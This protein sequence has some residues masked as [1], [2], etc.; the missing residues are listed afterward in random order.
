MLS[1]KKIT[2]NDREKID[3][4]LPYH[5]ERSCDFTLGGILMWRNFFCIEYTIDEDTF[6][7][8]FTSS[9]GDTAF[10]FPLGSNPTTGLK[11]IYDYCMANN[12]NLCFCTVTQANLVL[13]YNYFGTIK[14][15][16]ERAWYD[17]L[18]DAQSIIDLSGKKYRAQRNHINK[19]KNNYLDFSFEKIDNTNLHLAKNFFNDISKKFNKTSPSAIEEQKKVAE[20]IDKYN[21]YSLFGGILLIESKVIGLS[22]GEIINDTLFVHIERANT[23]YLGAYQMLVNMFAK[24]FAK[25]NVK[26]INREE[27]VGDAGLRK[28]KMSY[29]PIELIKKYTVKI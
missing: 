12:L 19:F 27:D 16:A 8:K 24:T 23:E 26:Y 9:E 22:I 15:T 25:E 6:F 10:T 14:A 21:Q 29:N 2:L 7:M 1:F 13:I 3:K 17:Y 28:S 11:K 18:Y 20:V 5:T 4:Y